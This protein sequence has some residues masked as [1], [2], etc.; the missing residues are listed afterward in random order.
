MGSELKASK[1]NKSMFE[2]NAPSIYQHL[3]KKKS[4]FIPNINQ[5][6]IKAE[7]H[8]N[9]IPAIFPEYTLHN[10]EHS[11]R[12]CD[13]MYYLIPNIKGLSLN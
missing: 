11:I 7:H 9:M 5:V 2:L 12:I 13:Y 8:L 1:D 6:A 3:A 10:I 4:E